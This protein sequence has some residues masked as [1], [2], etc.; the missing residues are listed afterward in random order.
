[1]FKISNWLF[2]E[3]GKNL[4]TLRDS[5]ICRNLHLQSDNSRWRGMGVR[6]LSENLRHRAGARDLCPKICDTV[7]GRAHFV[8]KCVAPCREPCT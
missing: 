6:L 8:R 3:N 4:V 7:Q 5:F 2:G 1:M